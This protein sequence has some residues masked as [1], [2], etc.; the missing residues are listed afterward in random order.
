MADRTQVVILGASGDLTAR[1]LIPGLF[2]S[3]VE[4]RFPHPVQVVGVARRPWDRAE[5]QSIITERV[6]CDEGDKARWDEFMSE[7]YYQQTHLDS[8]D[9]YTELA[10]TLNEI[11]GEAVNRVFYLA[12]KPELFLATVTGLHASGLL[13]QSTGTARVVVEKPFG[14]DLESARALNAELLRMLGEDQ[15]YRIDHYLGKETVQNLLAF[16]F[17]NAMF[18]PL[19]NHNHVEVVQITV[20]EDVLVGD[21]GGYYDSSG[22][23]RDIL[24]N[25]ALQILALVAMEPPSSL[26]GD[27]IRNEKVKVL[28]SLRCPKEVTDDRAHIVRGQYWGYRHE[29]GV[30]EDSQT[31]TYIAVRTYIDNWRWGG[32]PFLLRTGKG[33]PKRF[34]GIQVQFHMPPHSLFGPP[35]ACHLRPNALN[36]RIQPHEGIDLHFDVKAPGSGNEMVPAKLNFNYE[37]F[38]NRRI[39]EAY[40]RLLLDVI[41]GDQS[42]FIRSDEVEESWRWTDSLRELMPDTEL[43][44][45]EPKSWGPD[46]AHSLFGECEGR[47]AKE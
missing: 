5:F 45:Y 16:R 19:W 36:L 10:R 18:E 20:A 1:K 17:R 37:E 11:A 34:T 38:F 44:A 23:V 22:A 47:W 41:K 33:L 27:A 3:F 42:L 25:H 15:L 2:Q 24:Q 35:D 29:G 43:H 6:H 9:G 28:E 21:R 4:N 8:D 30:A 14:T 12:I 13:D 39:P 40:Q 46:A 26:Q 31:E 32:V 7:V